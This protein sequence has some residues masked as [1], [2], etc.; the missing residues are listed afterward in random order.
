MRRDLPT[1]H[2]LRG[3]ESGAIFTVML[4][5][6]LAATFW[7]NCYTFTDGSS[8]AVVGQTRHG[9]RCYTSAS[10]SCAPNAETCRAAESLPAITASMPQCRYVQP[11][12]GAREAIAPVE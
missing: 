3:H 8:I 11:L 6:I 4:T 1:H 9:A 5:A 12:A 10:A 7:F 2:P